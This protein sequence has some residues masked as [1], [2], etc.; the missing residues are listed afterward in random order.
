MSSVA[1]CV[2]SH[3]ISRSL[4]FFTS[5]LS[6]EFYFFL[7]T[8]KRSVAVDMASQLISLF[9]HRFFSQIFIFF[10]I[11][12]FVIFLPYS[13]AAWRLIWHHTSLAFRYNLRFIKKHLLILSFYNYINFYIF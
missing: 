1:S 10:R 9:L 8:L 11:S 2:V 7:A 5:I 6:L 4:F 12:Y 3:L 13:K